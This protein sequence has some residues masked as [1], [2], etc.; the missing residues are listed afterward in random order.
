MTERNKKLTGKQ[1]KFLRGLGH[2]LKPVLQV[3][4]NGLTETVIEQI[5]SILEM[6][7][8]IK[9]K[10]IKSSPQT[11]EEAGEKLSS[12]L[13]CQVA[14]LIGKTLLLYK[15]REEDPEIIIPR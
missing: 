3:G 9:I 7:E 6:H 14:Q 13:P 1:A 2:S 10:V 15:Q 4:K 12:T 11:A 5:R 8:L